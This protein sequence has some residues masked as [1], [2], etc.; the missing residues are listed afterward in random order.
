MAAVCAQI[1]LSTRVLSGF[2]DPACAPEQ[3]ESLLSRGES[4]IVFLTRPWLRAW[5]EA[6]GDGELLLAAPVVD[7]ARQHESVIA[8][9]SGRRLLKRE[10]FFRHRGSLEVRQFRDSE[11]ILPQLDEFFAQHIARWEDG[12]KPSYFL[13][14][15]QREFIERLTRLASDTGWLRFTR[16]DWEG[17]PIALEYGWCYRDTYFAG[18]SSFAVDLAHRLPRQVLLRQ[19]LLG[20]I[21]EGVS[22]YDFGTGDSP[23]KFHYATHVKYA[24]TWELLPNGKA[25]PRSEGK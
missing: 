8:A 2:G 18:P 4:D 5:W 6:A 9:A 21:A 11:A 1:S 17:R 24:R 22:T 19:S 7:L 3:W 23:Y 12:A 15:M 25:I 10:R 16:L 13:D 14:P 20:A